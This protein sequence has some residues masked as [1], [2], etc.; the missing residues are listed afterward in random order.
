M[1]ITFSDTSGNVMV[2]EPKSLKLCMQ[3]EFLFLPHAPYINFWYFD[4]GNEDKLSIM[5][6]IEK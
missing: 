1:K 5:W 4:R 6:D 2:F 3:S